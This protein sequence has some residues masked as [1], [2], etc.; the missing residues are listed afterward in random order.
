LTGYF[1][2]HPGL[3]YKPTGVALEWIA[4][5]IV[6]LWVVV[7]GYFIK[8]HENRISAAEK[9]ERQHAE[10]IASIQA[11]QSECQKNIAQRLTRGDHNFSRFDQ[12]LSKLK[13]TV[14]SFSTTVGR[15]EALHE[16]MNQQV[17]RMDDRI[18]EHQ[19][20]RRSYDSQGG[21]S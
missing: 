19:K 15:L 14:G 2:F 18:Y 4:E 13:T 16:S 10:K 11:E 7:V 12:Q 1:L 5:G 21:K 3:G 9:T 6:A 20:G 17:S 8:A